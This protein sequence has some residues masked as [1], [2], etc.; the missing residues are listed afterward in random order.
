MKSTDRKYAQYFSLSDMSST[1]TRVDGN[2]ANGVSGDD[3]GRK[4]L[5]T[6]TFDV[7]RQ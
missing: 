3:D 5:S 7:E 2:T 1:T 6:R 4:I